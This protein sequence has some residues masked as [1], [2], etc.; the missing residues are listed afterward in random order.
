M[1]ANFIIITISHRLQNSIDYRTNFYFR[2][3]YERK[4]GMCMRGMCVHMCV[5]AC[6]D[7][8]HV[9]PEV[10]NVGCLLFSQ[11]SL[12][13]VYLAFEKRDSRRL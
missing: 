1:H 8:S 11:P 10:G 3:H 4:L 5:G 13:F 12:L 6:A 9:E 7:E 2:C